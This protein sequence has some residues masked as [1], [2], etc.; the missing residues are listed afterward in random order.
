MGSRR[1]KIHAHPHARAF[2][3]CAWSAV[4]PHGC[5]AIVSRCATARSSASV[6]TGPS[7]SMCVRLDGG[8][9]SPQRTRC[10]DGVGRTCEPEI[11]CA[12]AARRGAPGPPFDLPAGPPF[13]ASSR[14]FAARHCHHACC[15]V[16]LP[17]HT[18]G[19][20]RAGSF[21]RLQSVSQ[22]CGT[23]FIHG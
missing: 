1:A 8:S 13:A 12:P 6:L 11:A 23:L 16:F 21:Y 5:D 7:T 14:W 10:K 3:V 22:G 4:W 9:R 20:P 19:V 17:N 15:S 2:R 18:V